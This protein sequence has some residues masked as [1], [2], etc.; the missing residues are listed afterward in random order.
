MLLRTSSLYPNDSI[1]RLATLSAFLIVLSPVTSARQPQAPAG[2]GVIVG[3]VVDAVSGAPVSGA[4][5]TAIASPDPTTIPPSGQPASM[6]TDAQGRFAFRSL[7]KGTYSLMASIGGRG[8]SPSGFMVTG[9]GHQ[10][11]AY[12]DGSYGQHRPGGPAQAIDLGEGG[13]I[14]D[15]VI[16]LWKGGAITG[17]VLDEA[18][19]PLVDVAVAAVERAADGRLL[20]GPSSRTDDRG[21][22]RIGTLKPGTYLIVVPQTQFVMPSST[23][24]SLLSGPADPAAASR[25]AA[26][27]APPLAPQEAGMKLGSSILVGTPQGRVTNTAPPT[28]RAENL[29]A[30][31]T[32]F[33]P[34]SV[35]ATRATPIAI[36]SGQERSGI[37][38]VLQPARTVEVSGTL[39]DNTGA[40]PNFGVHLMPADSGDGASVLEVATTAT[41]ARGAFVFPLVPSGSYSILAVRT[42][43]APGGPGP[44]PEPR[45]VSEMPGAWASQPLEVGDAKI[46][47]VV[48]TLRPGIRLTGK[49]DFVGSAERPAADRLR[50]WP[51]LMTPTQ[52]LFRSSGTSG[53]PIDPAGS[54]AVS[55]L[56]PGRYVLSTREATQSWAL[57]SVTIAGRDVTDTAIT[58]GGADV[59]DV[60]VVFT[61]Q[62]AQFTGTVSNAANA[63]ELDA[64]VFVFPTDRARWPDARVS[65]RTFRTVRVSKTGTFSVPNMIAGEYYV[66]AAL[67]DAA[68]DWP[69]VRLLTKLAPLATTIRID[70][71]QK[72]TASLRSVTVR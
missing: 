4:V 52:P 3:R 39:V 46:S 41:D 67:D 1:V 58:L 48:L 23:I 19:E 8:F 13:R 33:Y 66:V 44:A 47:N 51:I 64:S 24:E 70:P 20:T 53:A 36:R 40:V 57:Q 55:G 49:V 68:G 38:V 10:I 11:G 56:P 65:A 6:L 7:P 50:Q 42:G 22:Y 2:T 26:S 27:G 69:D 14:G 5:V 37:D 54:I 31:P 43:A 21:I 25:F 28:R 59:T 12:L 61:D 63:A 17:H 30:Y 16:R 18:G 15:A 35:T 72:Q 45:T 9:M 62:P 34:S 32:M 71:N 60:A 29:Y